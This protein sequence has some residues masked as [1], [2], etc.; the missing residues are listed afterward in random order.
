MWCRNKI[1]TWSNTQWD[2]QS[3]IY[4]II[5]IISIAIGNRRI[6]HHPSKLD[7]NLNWHI[8][9]VVPR[10][11]DGSTRMDIQNPAHQ[12]VMRLE[13]I[14]QKWMPPR[15]EGYAVVSKSLAAVSKR[16]FST[17]TGSTGR[18]SGSHSHRQRSSLGH[19]P[20]S[21]RAWNGVRN[22]SSKPT[23]GV[24]GA[25]CRKKSGCI[26]CHTWWAAN[27]LFWTGTLKSIQ[28]VLQLHVYC[29]LS[30]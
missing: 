26:S 9:F 22:F 18:T 14:Q 17:S 21:H 5:Y 7:D 28:L 13:G 20:R 3:Y 1:T 25:K 10:L 24:V 4:I 2:Y 6:S 11:L 30:S 16:H 8:L 23:V 29:L 19:L 15:Q 27:N 12:E